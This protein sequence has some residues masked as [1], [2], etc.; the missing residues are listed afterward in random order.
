MLALLV[1]LA[2]PAPARA[3]GD[4]WLAGDLHVHSC[5]SHD[6]Y[7]GASDDN[8][9]ADEAYTLG[10]G[11]GQRFAEA[12]ARGLDFLAITDHN[13]T[14]SAHDP[15][16]GSA[17][18]LGLP[19]YEASLRGHAQVL[20]SDEVLDPGDG[21]LGAVQRLADALHARGG[22][23]QANHPGYKA[24][25]PFSACGDTGALTWSYG[26]DLEPDTI[27]VLNPTSSAAVAE[28]FLECR[29]DRG[30]RPAVTGGS[31]NHWLTLSAA[32]IGFPTTW[33]L[34]TSRSQAAILA[35]LR[36]GRTA[37]SRV[38][39]S[40]GG[41][42]LLLEADA[43]RDGTFEAVQGAT[44]P[45]G[46]PMRV[47][48][49]GGTLSGLVRVRANGTTVVDGAAL[50]PGGAVTFTAPAAPGWVR[51]SL[52][53]LPGDEPSTAPGCDVSDQPISTCLHDQRL[54]ALTSPL[55]LR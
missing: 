53:A 41:A 21:S 48:A 37:V 14:R 44:V 7:C 36:D 50:A 24:S 30:G 8:T 3:V 27:E 42:P 18:V 10:E 47:R 28:R 9:G 11:V 5:F 16:V 31:D 54:L 40:A 51:A 34:A 23:L 4:T 55:Y 52:L 43:D 13:D 35:A 38:P 49:G 46:T 15:A 39:P 45:A 26:Y 25:A 1:L 19:A 17:G 22:V 2:V 12:A 6:V 20:G 33:V 29:L 32:G